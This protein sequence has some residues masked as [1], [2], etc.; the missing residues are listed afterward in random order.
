M[1]ILVVRERNKGE[2]LSHTWGGSIC[3]AMANGGQC[4]GEL[5]P[6]RVKLSRERENVHH[7]RSDMS[8][9]LQQ[10]RPHWGGL[11]EL[12]QREKV[13]MSST[14]LPEKTYVL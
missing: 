6:A 11:F 8:T 5:S 7:T 13:A 3:E 14:K 10:V 4:N 9:A 1:R 12:L 2:R